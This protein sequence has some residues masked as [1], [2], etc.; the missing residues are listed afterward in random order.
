MYSKKVGNN[1][2]VHYGTVFHGT[3]KTTF[4]NNI[5]FG[6]FCF[7]AMGGEECSIGNNV[8]M[9]SFV[10]LLTISHGY[11]DRKVPMQQQ[12]STCSPIII[13]DDI[14]IGANAIVV[15]GNNPLKIAKGCI[16]GAG[17]VVTKSCEIENGIYAGVPAKYI[18]SRFE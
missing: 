8:M 15:S 3:S 9:G 17:S 12:K 16:I 14:W 7:I 2:N 13:E 4:S 18:K 10:Q 11:K 1:L 5:D 6:R